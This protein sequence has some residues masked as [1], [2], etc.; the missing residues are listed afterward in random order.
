MTPEQEVA[1]KKQLVSAAK[2][3]LSLQVGIGVGCVRINKILHWLG[4]QGDEKYQIFWQFL[5]ATLGLPIGNERL[6][7]A[8][9][10][11]MEQDATLTKIETEFRPKLLSACIVIIDTYG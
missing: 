2:A 3:L 8:H 7:W 5:S 9:S 1:R 4:L 6:L 10:A 11:L